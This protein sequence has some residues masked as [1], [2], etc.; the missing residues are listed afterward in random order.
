MVNA[1]LPFPGNEGEASETGWGGGGKPCWVLLVF[2]VMSE[3][4]LSKP[5]SPSFRDGASTLH[6][7]RECREQEEFCYSFWGFHILRIMG[8]QTWLPDLSG[9]GRAACF[10]ALRAALPARAAPSHRPA[11]EGVRSQDEGRLGG[12]ESDREGRTGGCT[13]NP[14]IL[15]PHR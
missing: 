9:S 4:L 7:T 11:A 13:A 3:V 2:P 12:T 14:R 10:P 8:R 6:D 15:W 5:L 1:N